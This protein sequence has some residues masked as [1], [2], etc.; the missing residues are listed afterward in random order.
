MTMILKHIYKVQ[1]LFVSF[2]LSLL[3]IQCDI[4][5]QTESYLPLNANETKITDDGYLKHYTAWSPD[6]SKIAYTADEIGTIFSSFSTYGYYEAK[7]CEIKAEIRYRPSVSPDGQ[8]IAY[9]KMRTGHI[10]I[11]SLIDGTEKCLTPDEP[12]AVSPIWSP[13]G[14]YIAYNLDYGIWIISSNGD[15]PRQII[16]QEGHYFVGQSWSPDGKKLVFGTGK[17]TSTNSTDIWTINIDDKKI[18]ELTSNPEYNDRE[19]IWSPNGSEIAF[20]STGRDEVPGSIWT[21]PSHGGTIKQLNENI[22][23]VW[24]PTWSPDGSKIAFCSYPVNTLYIYSLADSSL[25][26]GFLQT[27]SLRYATPNW[28]PDGNSIVM[29]TNIKKLYTN[30]NVVSLEDLQIQSLV[31]VQYSNFTAPIWSA[32]NSKIIFYKYR[33]KIFAVPIDVGELESILEVGCLSLRNPA[34][35]PD[36][37]DLIFDNDY[38]IYLKPLNG[39]ELI[40]LSSNISSGLRNPTWAPDGKQIACKTDDGIKIFD[41]ISNKLEEKTTISGE[42]NDPSWSPQNYKYGTYIAFWKDEIGD[43]RWIKSGIYLFSLENSDIKRIIINGKYPGWSPDGTQ[44]SYVSIDGQ[45][46]TKTILYDVAN[47]Q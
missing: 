32:D 45:I 9:N 8:K 28:L 20:I 24:A 39:G 30:I 15:N 1:L 44:I 38:D 10:W 43:E 46:Y 4:K 12:E 31:D 47:L 16:Y 33:S 18:T 23:N 40:N 3:F 2:T 25:R 13:D 26:R 36:G 22:E 34:I 35:S 7:Y 19:P 14:N 21:I 29:N 27:T 11:Y 5:M 41:I 17:L 42:F 6:G 37:K